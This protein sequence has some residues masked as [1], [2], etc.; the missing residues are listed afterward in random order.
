MVFATHQVWPANRMFLGHFG[1][2][3]FFVLSGFLIVG[4]LTNRAHAIERGESSR[5][6]EIKQFFW[7]RSF[8][9]FPIYYLLL[10]VFAVAWLA[11]PHFDLNFSLY[12]LYITYTTNLGFAY[13]FNGWPNAQNFGHFWT[14]AVEEQ[15]YLLM[16]PLFLCTAPRL[17]KTI[18]VSLIGLAVAMAVLL[19]A[20]KMPWPTLRMDSLVNFGYLA[21][22]GLIAQVA[23]PGAGTRSHWVLL[24][25]A[26]CF[27]IGVICLFTRPSGGF[28]FLVCVVMGVSSA[29][30]ISEVIRNQQS[31]VVGFLEIAPLRWLGKVSYGFY[32]YHIFVKLPETGYA[33]AGI[34]AIVIANLA[35]TL[36]IA[37]LSWMLIEKPALN[38]RDRLGPRAARPAYKV[39]SD[40]AAVERT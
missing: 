4:I 35:V 29:V 22:G 18:A 40:P 26:L 11:W 36:L 25:F 33:V 27:A 5:L 37:Q 2:E 21:M 30:I 12:P 15:F 20:L 1:V 8:R 34:D 9:I 31:R 14:L 10:L 6:E 19:I 7:R 24:A 32:L 13:I 3:L 28:E 23:R 39:K 17:H 38:L 16:A